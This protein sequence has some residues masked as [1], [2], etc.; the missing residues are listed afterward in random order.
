MGLDRIDDWVVIVPYVFLGEIAIVR[1]HKNLKNY[2]L[3]DLIEIVKSSPDRIEPKCSLFGICGGCQ[4]QHIRHEKQ[5]DLKRH[6]VSTA[7]KKLSGITCPVNECLHGDRSYNYRSQ[8]TLH[9]QK[10]VSL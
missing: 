9:F 10:F 8:I 7:M 2:S 1:I 6:H 5:L 4:Y 3:D